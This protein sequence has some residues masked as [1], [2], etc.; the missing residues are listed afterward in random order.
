VIIFG[1]FWFLYIKKSNQTEIKKKKTKT[2][3]NRLVLGSVPFFRRKTS[4]NRF[5]SVFSVSN[6]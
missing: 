5:G 2:G 3:S 6:L 1:S 4:L